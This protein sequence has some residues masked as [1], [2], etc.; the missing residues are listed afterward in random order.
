[1]FGSLSDGGHVSIDVGPDGNLQLKSEKSLKEL[2]HL[3]Q[4][5]DPAVSDRGR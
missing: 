3:P 4:E 5:Q 2:Q 1:L